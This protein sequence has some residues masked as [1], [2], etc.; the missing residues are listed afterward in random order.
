MLRAAVVV[1]ADAP[2]HP[3]VESAPP[4]VLLRRRERL[5]LAKLI[6]CVVGRSALVATMLVDLCVMVCRLVVGCRRAFLQG[7]RPKH[8]PRG[9]VVDRDEVTGRIDARGGAA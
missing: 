6:Q 1:A 8:M 2:A 4:E 9:W 5:D 3:G 7:V